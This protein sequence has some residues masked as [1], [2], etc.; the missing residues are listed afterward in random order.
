MSTL[1]SKPINFRVEVGVVGFGKC[2]P[3]L[4]CP[5]HAT[6]EFKAFFYELEDGD[7][8][9]TPY[10]GNIELEECIVGE[11][12][13]EAGKADGAGKLKDGE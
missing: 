5:P 9:A 4:K 3:S 1:P 11:V 12:G 13:A 10:V 7:L 6:G 8:F 2:K